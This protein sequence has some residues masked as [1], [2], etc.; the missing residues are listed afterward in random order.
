MQLPLKTDVDKK[1]AGVAIFNY[2]KII[3]KDP[4]CKLVN[5]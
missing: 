1:L 4:R 5:Y 2:A 3:I